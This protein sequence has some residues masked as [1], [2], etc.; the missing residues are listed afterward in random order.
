MLEQYP[1][2]A[3]KNNVLGTLNVLN[4]ARAVGV[5][6]FVNIS[7]DKAANPTTVLGYSKRIAEKLTAWMSAQETDARYL[8][9]RFGNVIGSRGSAIPAFTAQIE[10]GGPVTVTH[11]DVTRFFMTIPEASKLVIQAGAIGDPGEVLIL[12]MG[13]PVRIL[14]VAKRMIAASG[15]DVEIVYTGLRHGEKLHEVLIDT[16]E[17]ADR[18]KHPKVSHTRIQPLDPALLDIA[19]WRETIA[20]EGAGTHHLVQ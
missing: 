12:D 5:G 11:P 15:K 9:V 6:T 13:R 10:A 16:D 7:T 4:A 18:S 3:W 2:E 8:S 1:D 19:V 20:D 17:I 14:D